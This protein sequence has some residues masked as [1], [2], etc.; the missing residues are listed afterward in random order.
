MEAWLADPLR[1]FDSV[2]SHVLNVYTISRRDGDVSLADRLAEDDS[3]GGSK[4][5]VEAKEKENHKDCHGHSSAAHVLPG[6]IGRA[7]T[8][9]MCMQPAKD[10]AAIEKEKDHQARAE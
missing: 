3:E 7:R 2:A 6:T 8:Q 5:R 10:L 4:A 1:D 9:S